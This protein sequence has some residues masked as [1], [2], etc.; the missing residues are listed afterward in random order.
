LKEAIPPQ[1]NR[2]AQERPDADDVVVRAGDGADGDYVIGTPAAPSS[3]TLNSRNEAIS[4][5]VDFAR[6]TH[7]SAWMR[8]GDRDPVLLGSF[9]QTDAQRVGRQDAAKDKARRAAPPR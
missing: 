7:V 6:S 2:P 1:A 8:D 5:A 3:L 9:R 4:H